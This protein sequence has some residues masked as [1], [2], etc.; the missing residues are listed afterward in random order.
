MTMPTPQSPPPGP[1]GH[2]PQQSPYGQP[3]PYPPQHLPHPPPP[4]P[5]P[6][7]WGGP[8]AGPPPRKDRTWLIVGIVLASM[9]ALLGLAYLG[10]RGSDGA[11]VRGVADPFPVAEYRLTVPKTLLGDEYRLVND[12]SADADA[13]AKK[14]SDATG[15]GWRVTASVMGS[16]NGTGTGGGTDGP[17][18]LALI[19]MYGQFK[20]PAQQR[21]GLL[22]GMREADGVSEPQPART[23]TPPGSDVELECTVLLSQDADGTSTVPVCAWGD[24]NTAAYVAFITP[25]D[26]AQDPGSVDLD[27]LAR[28][29]LKVREE[30]RQPIG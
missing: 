18:G 23:I 30:A 3:Q 29:V 20:D 9:A 27:A 13:R 26:A 24:A 1:Y 15:P 5:G 12:G 2:P 7:A 10:N 11:P 25:A 21:S 4:Y 14:E 17:H 6:G 19:G 22:K 8:P 28:Q 16:Y